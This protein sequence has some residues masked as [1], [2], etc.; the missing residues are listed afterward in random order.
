[1]SVM[2]CAR[3]RWAIE[4]ETF[5]TLNARELYGFEHNFGHGNN[6][7]SDVFATLAMLAFLTTRAR[8]RRCPLFR[9]ARDRRKRVPGLWNPMRELVGTFAF[10]DWRT[11]FQALTGDLGKEDCVGLIRTG[12]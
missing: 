8:R 3:R 1:M 12:P 5:Q 6:H 11:L 2:R 9:K 4:N 10:P 7:L